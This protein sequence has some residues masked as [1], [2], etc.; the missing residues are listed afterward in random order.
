MKKLI[1]HKTPNGLTKERNDV[2]A[3]VEDPNG[4]KLKFIERS[5]P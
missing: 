5:K 2:F 4:Y 1:G 3:F